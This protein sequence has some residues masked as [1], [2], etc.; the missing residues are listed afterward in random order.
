MHRF[1]VIVAA[2]VAACVTCQAQAAFHL[3]AIS[4][5]YSNASGTL[6]FIEFQTT[7]GSQQFI[8]AHQVMVSNIGNTLTNTFNIPTNLPSDSANRRFLIGTAGIQAAG[9]PAPDYIIPNNFLFTAGGAIN[10]F[11]TNSGS[12]TALPVDGL[13]SRTWGGNTNATNTPTNFAGAVGQVPAPSC[14]I[15]LVA[16]AAA[17]GMRRRRTR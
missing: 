2:G 1:N 15:A 8:G 16:G 6:Q 3:W 5:V 14:A 9:G 4:E 17:V 12:Y 10:F 7:F 11:G 13:L